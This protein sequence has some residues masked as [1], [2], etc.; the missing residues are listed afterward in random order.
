MH[1]GNYKTISHM[2]TTQHVQSE[3]VQFQ[4]QVS[5]HV[6]AYTETSFKLWYTSME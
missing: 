4:Q 3:N 1:T 5:V 2:L 6:L